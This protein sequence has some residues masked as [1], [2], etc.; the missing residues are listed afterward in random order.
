MIIFLLYI[1]DIFIFKER[2]KYFEKKHD[3]LNSIYLSI[4]HI[5]VQAGEYRRYD[6]TMFYM[7]RQ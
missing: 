2:G 7:G 4:F 6:I 1:F 3:F 5:I